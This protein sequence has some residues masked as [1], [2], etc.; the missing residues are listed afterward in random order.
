MVL[1]VHGQS[2]GVQGNLEAAV[3]DHVGGVVGVKV[4][5]HGVDGLSLHGRSHLLSENGR[6][7]LTVTEV[8]TLVHVEPQT[9]HVHKI[10]K[11]FDLE[12]IKDNITISYHKILDQ[13]GLAIAIS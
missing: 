1:C 5:C 11:I 2:P 13:Q 10:Q 12:D 3:V 9:I 6:C 4:S 8:G 7:T